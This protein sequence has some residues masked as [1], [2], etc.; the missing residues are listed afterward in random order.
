MNRVGDGVETDAPW[1]VDSLVTLGGAGH[2]AV[3]VE[4]PGPLFLEIGQE[5]A[6]AGWGGHPERL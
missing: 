3:A 6:F 5:G 2:A 4:Q 1:N